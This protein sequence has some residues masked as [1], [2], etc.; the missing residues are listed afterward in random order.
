MRLVPSDQNGAWVVME[1]K[2][3]HDDRTYSHRSIGRDPP[4]TQLTTRN[5]GKPHALSRWYTRVGEPQGEPMT[6]EVEEAGE[7]KG[8]W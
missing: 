6:Q 4:W 7:S 3:F 2:R 5:Y 8:S 1:E